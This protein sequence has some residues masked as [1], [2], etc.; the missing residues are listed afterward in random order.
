LEQ[1]SS[2]FPL[3]DKL[4]D[5]DVLP[6]TKLSPEA[7]HQATLEVAIAN[8]VF[9]HSASYSSMEMNLAMHAATPKIEAFYNYYQAVHN[10]SKGRE[11]GSWVD[12]YGDVVCDAETLR[13]LAGIETID[14]PVQHG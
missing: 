11:C 12:W 14:S 5:Q 2:F 4:T 6:S 3:L 1:P 8:G 7:L 9:E 10:Q 13:R